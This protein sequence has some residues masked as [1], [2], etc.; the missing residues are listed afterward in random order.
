MSDDS[1]MHS[2]SKKGKLIP[3]VHDVGFLELFINPKYLGSCISFPE[4]G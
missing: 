4:E 1:H 2:L 3:L